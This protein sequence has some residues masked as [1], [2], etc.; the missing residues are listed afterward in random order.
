M[1]LANVSMFVHVKFII[2]SKQL[3]IQEHSRCK[4][5]NTSSENC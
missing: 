2:A 1:K 5:C 3:N 4:T